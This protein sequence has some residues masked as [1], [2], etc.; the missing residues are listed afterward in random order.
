MLRIPKGLQNTGKI[1]EFCKNDLSDYAKIGS[2][3]TSYDFVG[4]INPKG[5]AKQDNSFFSE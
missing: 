1:L 3:V 4:K 2:I 5:E